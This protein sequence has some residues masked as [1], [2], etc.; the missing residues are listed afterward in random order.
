MPP[1]SASSSFNIPPPPPEPNSP[2]SSYLKHILTNPISHEIPLR[3][4]YTNNVLAQSSQTKASSPTGASSGQA[5]PELG[6]F[7]HQGYT[8][9][10][11]GAHFKSCLKEQMTFIPSQK[12]S[13][14]PSFITSFVRRCFTEELCLVDFTQAM[15]A[16]DYLKILDDRRKREL[17]ACLRR[18]GVDSEILARD[19]QGVRNRSAGIS[20]W[21]SVMEDKAKK[22]ET[23]YTHVY[24][25][26]RRWVRQFISI[27]ALRNILTNDSDFD[28]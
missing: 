15:T 17:S 20:E 11:A 26:L 28:Q 24:I 12:H 5:S 27:R 8:T 2:P 10:E 1:P 9:Q 25:G 16:L 13:L 21:L 23:L 3:T 19:T 4:M 22:I 7:E 6:H 14:P 18:L